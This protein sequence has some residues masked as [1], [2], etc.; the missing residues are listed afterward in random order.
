MT[1]FE[2]LRIIYFRLAY[3]EQEAAE[4]EISNG[5]KSIPRIISLFIHSN[6]QASNLSS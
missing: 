1:N 5:K 3:L 2:T 6:I 4:I